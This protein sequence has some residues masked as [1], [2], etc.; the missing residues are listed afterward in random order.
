LS[1]LDEPVGGMFDLRFVFTA[2]RK[3]AFR[4]GRGRVWGKV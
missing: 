4:E 1:F 3:E 2:K